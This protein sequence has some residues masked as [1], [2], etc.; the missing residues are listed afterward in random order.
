MGLFVSACMPRGA[1]SSP[2]SDSDQNV[3]ERGLSDPK[4]VPTTFNH[5][6][7]SRSEMSIVTDS[8]EEPPLRKREGQESMH[9]F[10]SSSYTDPGCIDQNEMVLQ[11]EQE[12]YDSNEGAMIVPYD[13]LRY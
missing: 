5:S 11:L 13:H 3:K 2:V 8:K 7:S 4:D 12:Y 6:G 1:V 10:G 9:S